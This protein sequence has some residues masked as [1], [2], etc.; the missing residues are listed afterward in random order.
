LRT[1]G[2]TRRVDFW[3]RAQAKDSPSDGSGLGGEWRKL[4][5]TSDWIDDTIVL[6]VPEET[7]SLQYGVGVAGP[8]QV[9]LE[10]VRMEVVSN[11]VPLTSAS[12]HPPAHWGPSGDDV[13]AYAVALDPSV[14]RGGHASGTV[15]AV[16]PHP[17]GFATISQWFSG[18]YLGKRLRFSAWVKAE[19]VAG[20]AGL[21]MRVD[22]QGIQRP[23]AFDNMQDRPIKGTLDW[24][25]YEVV[26]DVAPDAADVAFGLLLNGPGQVWIDDAAFE[27]VDASV[28]TTGRNPPGPRNLD[29][30]Q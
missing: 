1:E 7:D 26:L 22:R 27:V 13:E 5:S 24:T 3:A 12:S 19:G 10:K 30:E 4:P 9:W 8:G 11:D 15:R 16:A 29:F 17:R 25:R 28:P 14:K 18:M 21:W 2:A 23:S 6:D 20:W